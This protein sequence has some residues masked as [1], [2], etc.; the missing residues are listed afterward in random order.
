M[1]ATEIL[2]EIQ[3]MPLNEKRRVWAK[4]NDEIEQTK[5]GGNLSADKTE[6]H[7]REFEREMFAI[8]Q[9]LCP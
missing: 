9:T 5:T 8:C 4:L 6:R 3:K 7:E 1:T 2:Q